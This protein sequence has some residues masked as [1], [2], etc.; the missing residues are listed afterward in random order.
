MDNIMKYISIIFILIFLYTGVVN[1]IQAFK[2]PKLTNTELFLRLPHTF[3][4]DF[5]E[6]E[7][8][9]N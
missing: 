8:T 9:K 5:I 3:V 4:C 7:I 6:C 1:T 2:C